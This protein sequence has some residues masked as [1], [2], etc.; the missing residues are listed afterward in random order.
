MPA[1]AVPTPVGDAQLVLD[2]PARPVAAALF[3]HG[4]GGGISAPDLIAGRD[5]L[6]SAGVAVG[7]FVQPYRVAGRRAPAPAAQLDV[8]FAAGVAALRARRGLRRVPLVVGGRS[9]GARVACRT[10]QQVGATAVVC[11]AFPLHPPGRPETTRL[12]ELAASGV[13]TLVVQGERDAF[14]SAEVLRTALAGTGRAELA[15]VTVYEAAGADH[16]LKKGTAALAAVVREFVLAQAE[17]RAGST[18]LT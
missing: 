12:P 18:S 4:A 17:T 9:S 15:D 14:G 2:V 3:G 6:V 13:P 11:L 10:A 7:L 16:G 1:S 5:A 8:A